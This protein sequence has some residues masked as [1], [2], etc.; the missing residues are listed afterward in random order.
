MGKMTDARFV[1]RRI[2]L[3]RGQHVMLSGDLAKLYEVPTKALNRAVLRNIERFPD[4]FMF[5]LSKEENSILRCQFGTLGWGQYS[6]YLPRAFTEEG[7]AMLSGLLRSKKAVQVN[8]AI[9]R[10]FVRL[11]WLLTGDRRLADQVAEHERRLSKHEGDIRSL[12]AAVPQ[13]PEPAPEPRPVIGFRPRIAG[14]CR[15]PDDSCPRVRG[16]HIPI[17][18]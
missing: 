16:K 3:M 6:K 10:A 4:D 2:F 1:E 5:Q 12:F 7:I 15:G 17:Q 13:L 11:R 14:A 8:I 18:G 9:M